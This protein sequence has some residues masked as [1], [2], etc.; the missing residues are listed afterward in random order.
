VD[1]VFALLYKITGSVYIPSELKSQ[2]ERLILHISDTP[3]CFFSPLETLLKR[4]KPDYIIHTGDLVDNLKLQFSENLLSRYERSLKTIMTIMESSSAKQIYIVPGNH[5]R[6]NIIE[7]FSTRSIIKESTS[8]INIEGIDIRIG[9]YAKEILSDSQEINLFGHDLSLC[10]S[11][12]E[13]K[14]YLNGISSINII[15][16]KSRRIFKLLYPFGTDDMRL[17]RGKIGL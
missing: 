6:V 11:N 12:L 2:S 5:D 4:L 7:N 16:T 10:S 14:L 3:I 13:N 15:T 1:N 9:H 17:K 8:N